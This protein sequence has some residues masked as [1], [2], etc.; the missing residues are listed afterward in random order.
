M[1]RLITVLL[2]LSADRSRRRRKC[3]IALLLRKRDRVVHGRR[4][5]TRLQ[6]CLHLV[7]IGNLNR[8]LRPG[9]LRAGDH[10]GYA[11]LVRLL[12]CLVVA[13]RDRLALFDLVRKYLEFFEQDCR[14]DR[15]EARVHADADVLVFVAALPVNADGTQQ[16][17]KFVIVRERRAA[18][19][20]AT[21]RFGGK[22]AGRSG[23]ADSA[24]AR[25]RPERRRNLAQCRKAS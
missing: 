3:P 7:A 15:V 20:I 6:S 9:R 19:A 13:L 18:V 22:K 4:N 8:V 2:N 11:D 21:K 17:I 23:I 5:A 25:V 10:A 14:L 16:F 24:G 12:Q 1:G